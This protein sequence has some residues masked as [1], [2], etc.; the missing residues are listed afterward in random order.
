MIQAIAQVIKMVIV[1]KRFA[2]SIPT[3]LPNNPA[4]IELNNGKNTT[5][6][7]I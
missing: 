3:T 5:N 6:I 4:I 7:Y 2:P 1:V